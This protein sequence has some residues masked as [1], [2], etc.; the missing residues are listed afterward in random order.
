MRMLCR[1]I[2][3]APFLLLAAVLRA[4]M[5]AELTAALAAFRADG[6]RGWAYTQT[7]SSTNHS[8]VE[9]YDPMIRQPFSWKLI[10][11]D[12][13]APTEKELN[14]YR[15]RVAMRSNDGNVSVKDQ[16]VPDS[17]RLVGE[18]ADTADYSFSLQPGAK[19]DRTAQFMTATFRLHRPS[20][21][22]VRVE[23]ANRE[24]FSPM[25]AVDITEARTVM[26]YSLPSGETPSLLLSVRTRVRGRSFW[27][28][29]LDDELQVTY[30][31]H[32]FAGKKSPTATPAAP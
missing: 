13:H 22:I 30:A 27:F 25:F 5:P 29:S 24:P 14:D 31:D 20:G 4:E 6:P 7:T 26:D 8:M 12:G 18:T 32:R 21:T 15:N 1:I 17:C 9:T 19:E 16:I 28:R 23:L 3:L 10:K 11:R 2:R